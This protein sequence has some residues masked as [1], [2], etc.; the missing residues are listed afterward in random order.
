MWSKRIMIQGL[1]YI[2]PPEGLLTQL[3]IYVEEKFEDE[4]EFRENARRSVP[5]NPSK[6]LEPALLL[7]SIWEA[8]KILESTKSIENILRKLD[9]LMK[10]NPNSSVNLHDTR[11]VRPTFFSSFKHDVLFM[12]DDLIGYFVAMKDRCVSLVF[13]YLCLIKI[14]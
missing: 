3:N 1:R 2:N 11:I 12:L 8:A 10:E 4:E 6:E 13:E 9:Q 7:E 14:F 5:A